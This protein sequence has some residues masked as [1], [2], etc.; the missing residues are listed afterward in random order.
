[1]YDALAK[2]LQRATGDVV[3]YLNAGDVYHPAAFDVLSDVF[4]SDRTEWVTGISVLLN[5]HGQVFRVRV[6]FRYRSSLIRAGIYGGGGLPFIQQESTFW[7]K[8]LNATIDFARL[9]AFKYAG[10]FF[11]WKSFA[12][13]APLTIVESFL[14]AFRVHPGQM[15]ENMAAYRRELREAADRPR[16]IDH[17]VAALDLPVW[18]A[19][20]WVKKALNPRDM[21]R[22]DRQRRA[23]G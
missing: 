3:A 23:W 16:L 22:W 20:S 6:P 8:R 21:L 10:D 2:G 5:P 18:Y 11:L 1:M 15:S 9:R 7:S 14:G 4:E 12:A 19:P 17:V 13:A